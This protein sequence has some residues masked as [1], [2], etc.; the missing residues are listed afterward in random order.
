MRTVVIALLTFF[1]AH[2]LAQQPNNLQ[3]DIQ[4]TA[5]PSEVSSDLLYDATAFEVASHQLASAFSAFV[6][7]EGGQRHLKAI[8]QRLVAAQQKLALIKTPPEKMMASWLAIE[9]Y[10][11]QHRGHVFN[12]VD[13]SLEGGWGIIQNQFRSELKTYK[14]SLPA[15]KPSNELKLLNYTLELEELLSQYMAYA[16]STTGGYGVSRGGL[17]IEERVQ[18]VE[19][20]MA[21]LKG[22]GVDV[23][24]MQRKWAYIKKTI[25]AYNSD[26]APF[27]VIHTMNNIRK[28]IDQHLASNES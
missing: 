5:A 7:F 4:S 26:I 25:L 2:I 27:V 21:E 19:S 12:G 17:T 24:Q 18:R 10:L 22:S 13:M 11:V 8:D 16:N 23:A 1:S 3:S 15:A 28:N 14:A 9:D 20:Q 6:Y